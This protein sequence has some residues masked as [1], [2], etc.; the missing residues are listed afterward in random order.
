MIVEVADL[1]AARSQVRH[2]VV[3][4]FDVDATHVYLDAIGAGVLDGAPAEAAPLRIVE[5]HRSWDGGS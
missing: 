5:V 2:P 1:D 4:D 3:R